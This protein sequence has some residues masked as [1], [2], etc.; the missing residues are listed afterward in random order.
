MPDRTAAL[1]AAAA[2]ARR[3]LDGLDERPV[4]AQTDAAAVRAALGGPLPQDGEDP[5]AVIDML[6]AGAV[7]GRPSRSSSHAAATSSIAA[8]AGD[9]T[10]RAVFWSQADTSQSAASAA[11][12]APP[13]TKPK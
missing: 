2:H 8:A 6:V 4:D 3:F 5:A 1:D 13:V 10:C 7:D 9:M 12:S 11:G